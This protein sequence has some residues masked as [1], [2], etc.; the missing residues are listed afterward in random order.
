MFISPECVVLV[1]NCKRSL[2]VSGEAIVLFFACMHSDG[3]KSCMQ[4]HASADVHVCCR[5]HIATGI[6]VAVGLLTE[7]SDGGSLSFERLE[8]QIWLNER[9]SMV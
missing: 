1:N 9:V 8:L 7:V 2:L 3:F 5:V 6:V 4:T